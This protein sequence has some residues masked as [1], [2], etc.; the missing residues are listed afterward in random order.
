MVA[1]RPVRDDRGEVVVA[2]GVHAGRPGD[3]LADVVEEVRPR[4]ALDHAAEQRVAVGGVGVPSPRLV[5]QR[6]V[7]E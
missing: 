4:G 5:Q 2:E 6:V 1:L 7:L 3:V